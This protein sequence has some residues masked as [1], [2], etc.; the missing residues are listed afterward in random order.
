MSIGSFKSLAFVILL[1]GLPFDTH[2]HQREDVTR[3]FYPPRV[4]SLIA[5]EPIT[6]VLY[7]RKWAL[8]S[9]LTFMVVF[10]ATPGSVLIS[11]LRER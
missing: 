4:C 9:S 6:D 8:V 5:N 10:A 3:S 1:H 7:G 2:S 11:P